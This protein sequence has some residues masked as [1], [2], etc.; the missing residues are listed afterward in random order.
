M[1]KNKGIRC[2]TTSSCC[3][4]RKEF[5]TLQARKSP[6]HFHSLQNNEANEKPSPCY[7]TASSSNDEEATKQQEALIGHHT[8]ESKALKELKSA[9]KSIKTNSPTSPQFTL[10]SA[11]EEQRP[12]SDK[13]EG[14]T[15]AQPQ[16][17]GIFKDGFQYTRFPI[18]DNDLCIKRM[19]YR[20]IHNYFLQFQFARDT[21]IAEGR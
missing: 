10:H 2:K 7:D 14:R 19:D 3:P 6:L 8:A 21:S 4:R 16:K 15:S 5:N 9:V 12:S 13:Q 20:I 17:S 11:P 18:S 1:E